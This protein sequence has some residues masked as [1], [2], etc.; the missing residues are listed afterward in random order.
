MLKFDV[1]STYPIVL[2][3]S[4]LHF[5]LTCVAMFPYIALQWISC[6]IGLSW[7]LPIIFLWVFKVKLYK[8]TNTPDVLKVLK[9]L[10]KYSTIITDDGTPSG[11][12]FSKQAIGYVQES[13]S[14]G[15]EKSYTL[16]LIA[17][18]GFLEK[19]LQ[20]TPVKTE[21]TKSEKP[22]RLDI[23][24]REGNYYCLYYAKRCL[25]VTAFVA[26]KQQKMVVSKVREHHENYQHTVVYLYG[27]PGSGKSMVGF[28][29]AKELSATFCNTFDPTEPGDNLSKLYNRIEPTKEKPLVI[30]IDEFDIL[31]VNIHTGITPHK[32]IPIQVRNKVTWNQFL[33]RIQIG[34]YPNVIVVLTSNRT[35]EFI[36][37]L[38][39][40]YIRKGRVDLCCEL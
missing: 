2:Y 14:G 23:Y 34:M 9:K 16:W 1:L 10:N 28:L 30:V 31:L 33:D 37:E 22:I 3:R 36:N 39:P 35:P 11:V 20:S 21:D 18:D 6:L 40:S 8:L 15:Q 38:D 26:R 17:H 7:S 24:E 29:I 32:C 19:V 4:V 5:S 27:N 12:I 25:D 13:N